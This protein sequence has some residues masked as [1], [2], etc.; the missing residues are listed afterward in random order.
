MLAT[1]L[2]RKLNIKFLLASLNTLIIKKSSKPLLKELNVAFRKPPMIQIVPKAAYGHVPKFF[3]CLFLSLGT[4][5]SVFNDNKLPYKEITK[6]QK[7]R[8]SF[9]LVYRRI[10]IRE[11][12][13]KTHP[14]D[15]FYTVQKIFN[16]THLI[17]DHLLVSGSARQSQLLF[18][19]QLLHL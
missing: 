18:L 3:F 6:L 1:F 17:H 16:L 5:T 15:I 19:I 2:W 12:R 11:V 4:I 8:V 10:R 14:A 13:T 9:M 7:S